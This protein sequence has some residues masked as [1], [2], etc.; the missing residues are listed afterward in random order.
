M[1]FLNETSSRQVLTHFWNEA[2]LLGGSLQAVDMFGRHD[3]ILVIGRAL[4]ILTH[5]QPLRSSPFSSLYSHVAGA[6]ELGRGIALSVA[7]W[8]EWWADGP[9]LQAASERL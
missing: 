9:K 5:W 7:V 4:G 2:K 3:P 1:S 6:K 8:F